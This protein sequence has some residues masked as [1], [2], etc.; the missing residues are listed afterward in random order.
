MKKTL[1]I[2]ILLF[3]VVPSFAQVYRGPQRGP[4]SRRVFYPPPMTM[5]MTDWW[6]YQ[7]SFGGADGYGNISEPEANRL[8]E[9][10]KSGVIS[11]FEYQAQKD[12][13]TAASTA[14]SSVGSYGYRDPTVY[15]GP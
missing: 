2:I 6:M 9:E 3:F 15:E 1:I 8:M 7:Q 13:N 10:N 5:Q 12:Q 14:A 4:G 11:T